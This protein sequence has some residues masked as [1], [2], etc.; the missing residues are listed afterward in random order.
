MEDKPPLV[1]VRIRALPNTIPL[2]IE[3]YKLGRLEARKL[4]PL[5]E[6]RALMDYVHDALGA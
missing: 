4:V 3:V 2:Q 5:H 1:E 6:A